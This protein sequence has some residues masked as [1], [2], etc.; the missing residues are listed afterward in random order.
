MIGTWMQNIG[1]A[2]LVLQL[3][4]SAYKLGVVSAL[5]FLPM[6]FFSLLAG[7]FIDRFPKKRILLLTQTSLMVLAFSL[8]VLTWLQAIAYWHILVLAVLLGL[9]NTLDI[10]ARQ[11][12]VIELVGKECLMNAIALNSTVFNLGRIVGPAIAGLLIGLLG[13]APCFFINGFSFFA[14][15]I[16]LLLIRTG[17]PVT[18]KKGQDITREIR[19]GLQYIRHSR[20]IILPL[21][22]LGFLSTFTMNYNVL[23]PVFAK[24][25]LAQGALGFGILM[26]ALGAGS[27]AGALTLAAGSQKGPQKQVLYGC[28]LGSAAGLML[29]SFV[30][31]YWLACL[32]LGL[33]GF[34]AI[35]FIATANTTVQINSQDGMRGRV[36]SVYSLV[37]AGFAPLGSLFAGKVAEVLGAGWSILISGLIGLVA[38]ITVFR[39]DRPPNA[40]GFGDSEI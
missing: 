5:Q 27:F 4:D 23:V 14:V 31:Q 1:Q 32:V 15:L 30:R 11:S 10:P 38:V 34:C 20:A 17:A 9:V 18:E 40:P 6:T 8:A 28:G 3:T 2:W 19:E 29:L 26:T 12:L 36:M 21:I 39:V 7:P 13:I 22:M 25:N 16:S 33:I 37:L 35:A 24:E